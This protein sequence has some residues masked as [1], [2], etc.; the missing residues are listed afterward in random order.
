MLIC[1]YTATRLGVLV[2]IKRNV[3]VVT[4]C[5]LK[6]YNKDKDVEASKSDSKNSSKDNGEDDNKDNK[7]NKEFQD[8][9]DINLD[10]VVKTLYYKYINFIFF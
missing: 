6:N 3:K 7:K 4:K 9:I 5:A 2:Y 10:K 8:K 1:I